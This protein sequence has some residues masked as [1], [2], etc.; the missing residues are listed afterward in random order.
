[1]RTFE[2]LAELATACG[3]DLPPGEWLAVDQPMVD[4]FA[5]VTGDHQWIHVDA[6][7]AAKGP[8]GTTVAHGYLTLSLLPALVSSVYDVRQDAGMRINYGLDR[9]RFP[10][11]VPV[12][13]RVRARVRPETIREVPSGR[14]LVASVSIECDA[15]DKPVCVAQT[16][17]LFAAAGPD[18]KEQG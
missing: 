16:L 13:S 4:A 12:P 1:M 3:Q 6:D 7:R 10:A 2:S 14:Q 11:T 15:R 9:L 17:V 5:E 18:R 8:F